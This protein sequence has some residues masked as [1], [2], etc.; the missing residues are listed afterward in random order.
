MGNI[1]GVA[2]D[3]EGNLINLEAAHHGA[4]ILAAAEYGVYL[5]LDE[6]FERIPHFIGGPDKKIAEE[7]T[8]LAARKDIKV[9]VNLFL[10]WDKHYYEALLSNINI[11]PRPGCVDAIESFKNNGLKVS[12]ASNTPREHAL[13]LLGKSGLI[14]HFEKVHLI[15]AEDVKNPKPTPDVWVEAAH[16]LGVAASELLAFDDSPR[17]IIGASLAGATCIGM[18]VYNRVDAVTALIQA[19]AKRIFMDWREINVPALIENLK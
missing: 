3:L 4:H 6:C 8:A 15:F 2:F 7:I 18:P 1:L 12:I 14:S 10:D 17:G 19:G 9:D 5:T 13:M 16:C 11:Q